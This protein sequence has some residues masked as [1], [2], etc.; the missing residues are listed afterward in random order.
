MRLRILDELIPDNCQVKKNNQAVLLISLIL[1]VRGVP[2]GVTPKPDGLFSQT[3]L[4]N[5]E[6]FALHQDVGV[7]D[8]FVRVV[9]FSDAGTRPT[10]VGEPHAHNGAL[11][12][13][14][15]GSYS[16]LNSS[17]TQGA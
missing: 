17:C 12:G 5:Y 6:S 1:G 11:G 4:F 9:Q 13:P 16:P 3:R 8:L 7:G 2:G 14:V 10:Q 15:V